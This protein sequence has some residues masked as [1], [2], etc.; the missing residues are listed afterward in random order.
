MS[1]PG[2]APLPEL[3]ESSLPS[4]GT[5]EGAMCAFLCARDTE[6]S[7]LDSTFEL[8]RTGRDRGPNWAT[9]V[10]QVPAGERVGTAPEPRS[11]QEV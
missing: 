10:A 5:H 1:A 7:C 8:A 4:V 6:Y 3:L 9:T 11:P 2:Q